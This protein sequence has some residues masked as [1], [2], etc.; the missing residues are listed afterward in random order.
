MSSRAEDDVM[1]ACW[2]PGE[3]VRSRSFDVG[4]RHTLNSF[5]HIL[6]VR[7]G[8][9]SPQNLI[10]SLVESSGERQVVA[11]N[12]P[13]QKLPDLDLVFIDL[14]GVGL[15]SKVRQRRDVLRRIIRKV[16]SAIRT[17]AASSHLQ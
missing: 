2:R 8:E 12:G 3:L 17:K 7:K 9:A 14:F 13:H 4:E 5:D 11:A 6:P 15:A 1:R 16:S 10:G